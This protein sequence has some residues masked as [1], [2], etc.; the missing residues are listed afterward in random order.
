MLCVAR[1]SVMRSPWPTSVP[2]IWRLPCHELTTDENNAMHST[3]TVIAM[4]SCCR[5][6]VVVAMRRV[7]DSRFR[8]HDVEAL[9]APA[10]IDAQ[11]IRRAHIHRKQNFR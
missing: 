7:C 3:P 2:R 9:L 8:K 11:M 6:V 5:N 4:A 1:L 10:E